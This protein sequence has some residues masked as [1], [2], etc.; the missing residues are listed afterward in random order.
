MRPQ[1][2]GAMDMRRLRADRFASMSMIELSDLLP[3]GERDC[4][5]EAYQRL[6]EMFSRIGA[7][8]FTDQDRE[9]A[10]LPPRGN[11]GWTCAEL[12]IHES[13][14]QM[15]MCGPVGG[16]LGIKDNRAAEILAKVV[17]NI[18]PSAPDDMSVIV[19]DAGG[20]IISTDFTV[21]LGDLRAAAKAKP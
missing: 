5:R 16:I 8:I 18:H 9:T 12:R 19:T 20:G 4:Q 15:A 21:K 3:R 14:R 11:L 1:D 10:G 17:A 13:V 2:M 6:F 7:D